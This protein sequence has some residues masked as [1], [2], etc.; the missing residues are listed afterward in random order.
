MAHASRRGSS[1]VKIGG[2][3]GIA[4]CFIGLAV[5]MIALFGFNAAFMLSPLPVILGVIG[6]VMAVIG[7]VVT[8][9]L[10]EEETQPIAALFVCLTGIIIGMIEMHVWWNLK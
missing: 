5:F 2:A 4:A 9:H 8:Q 7:G 3:L 1:L 10:G 6:L